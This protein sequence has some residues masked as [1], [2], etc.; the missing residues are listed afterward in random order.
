[1]FEKLIANV[2]MGAVRHFATAL[3][4]YLVAQGLAD[5]SQVQPLIGSLMFLAGLG[6]SAYDKW[7][8]KKK[9]GAAK[10]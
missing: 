2:G 4:G 8:A 5:Q 3:G 1:M 6:F 7:A 9:L 10:P